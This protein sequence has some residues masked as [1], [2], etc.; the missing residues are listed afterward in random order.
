MVKLI[1][2]KSQSQNLWFHKYIKFG[3]LLITFLLGVFSVLA[4]SQS[5]KYNKVLSYTP[6][7]N[8]FV[9]KNA[10]VEYGI[11][12][13][14]Q[15]TQWAKLQ[16]SVH[17]ISSDVVGYKYNGTVYDNSSAFYNSVSTGNLEDAG[18]SIRASWQIIYKG[19][20]LKAFNDVI[21]SGEI[22]AFGS[23]SDIDTNSEI[24]DYEIANLKISS[25]NHSFTNRAIESAIR[26]QK[27][28][29]VS[30]V[31]GTDRKSNKTTSNKKTSSSTTS[32]EKTTKASNTTASKSN[33]TSKREYSSNS[34]NRYNSQMEKRNRAAQKEVTKSYNQ[35][36]KKA[37]NS[38]NETSNMLAKY[39]ENQRK[40]AESKEKFKEKLREDARRG[41]Q[42]EANKKEAFLRIYADMKET[43][44]DYINLVSALVKSKPQV[45]Y[46][47]TFL[48]ILGLKMGSRFILL[49]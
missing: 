35:S 5:K 47:N 11:T 45:Y 44:T 17:E 21:V 36:V 19:N 9:V 20:V 28:K 39:A 16:W 49:Q 42:K 6:S 43:K 40:R 30:K 32:S 48:I 22:N 41:R 31:K 12:I 15:G 18:R 26:E 23:I 24:S 7:D 8:G 37:Q 2:I 10:N 27:E 1:L 25:T 14:E 34:G 4:Q 38:M 13:Q 33:T 29:K 3:V 46:L